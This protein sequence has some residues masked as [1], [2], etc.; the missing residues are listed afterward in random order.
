MFRR[1][2]NLKGVERLVSFVGRYRKFLGS[3][4]EPRELNPES[5]VLF[6]RPCVLPLWLVCLH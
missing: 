4:D 5:P 3:V 2:V 6:R 1:R